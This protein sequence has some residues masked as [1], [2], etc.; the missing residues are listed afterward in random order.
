[1]YTAEVE[2]AS[3]SQG[4]QLR[5]LE[6]CFAEATAAAQLRYAE[7]KQVRCAVHE[8]STRTLETISESSQ[9]SRA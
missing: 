7:V 3:S 4:K 1:M 8:R 9:A 6:A 5:E 2:R